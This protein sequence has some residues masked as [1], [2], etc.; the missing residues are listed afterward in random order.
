MWTRRWYPI[1]GGVGTDLLRK[2]LIFRPSG[3]SMALEKRGLLGHEP[4]SQYAWKIF[5]VEE[6]TW[7]QKCNTRGFL[8]RSSALM[9][10]PRTIYRWT[11]LYS[12]ASNGKRVLPLL[13]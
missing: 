5:R 11:S 9:S 4:T 12:L 7:G 3:I 8:K 6:I 2:I 13:E 1:F 10:S